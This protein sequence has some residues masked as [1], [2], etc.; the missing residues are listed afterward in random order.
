MSHRMKI[1]QG[2]SRARM[3]TILRVRV[4]SI[5]AIGTII[6]VIMKMGRGRETSWDISRWVTG[7]SEMHTSGLHRV[8]ARGKRTNVTIHLQV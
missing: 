1:L 7:T 4:D 3:T 5:A 8:R 6:I 2:R